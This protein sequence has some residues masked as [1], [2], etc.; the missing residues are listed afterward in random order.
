MKKTLTLILKFLYF[1][2]LYANLGFLK[3]FFIIIFYSYYA[4]LDFSPF[5]S[6]CLPALP[7]VVHVHGS[8]V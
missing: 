5:D 7:T 8:Y 1:S 4:F 3:L 2:V 6:P